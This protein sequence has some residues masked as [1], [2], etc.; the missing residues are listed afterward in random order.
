M[1]QLILVVAAV[2]A[3]AVPIGAGAQQDTTAPVLLDFTISPTTF[4]AGSGPVTIQWC[5]TASDNL[6]GV[7][8][9]SLNLVLLDGQRTDGGSVA[10]SSSPTLILTGCSGFTFD[11]F[12]PYGTYGLRV[13]VWDGLQS[14]AY[15]TGGFQQ[16]EDL[17][18]VSTCEIEN[19][20]GA[21]LPDADSDGTPDDADNCPTDSNPLQEDTDSDLLGDACDPFPFDRDNEQAQCEQDLAICLA[22]GIPD[23]DN[24]GEADSTDRCPDTPASVEVDGDGCSLAQFCAPFPAQS[25]AERRDCRKADW[26]ND[27]PTMTLRERDCTIDNGGTRNRSDD[28]CVPAAP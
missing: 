22:A 1:R 4:D 17:C 7:A 10:P 19:R 3:G 11:Q 27:E 23:A 12:R 9:I 26:K 24:D 25:R 5:A 16:T 6:A 13:S 21:A 28:V 15:A 18:L 20:P 8:E 14:R 2:L